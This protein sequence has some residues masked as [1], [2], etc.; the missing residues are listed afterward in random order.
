MIFDTLFSKKDTPTPEEQGVIASS[1]QKK[2]RLAPRKRLTQKSPKKKVHTA[3]CYH[4]PELQPLSQ[5]VRIFDV[6][7]RPIVTEKAAQLSE[8]GVYA[9]FV[10][11]SATKHSV[12]AA[13]EA[14]YNVSPVKVR[15]ARYPSR[16]KRVRVSGRE[17]EMGASRLRKRAYVY[18][19]EGEKIQLL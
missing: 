18:L 17:R 8:R 19:K 7:E 1:S 5:Q 12:C 16:R 3:R 4:P 13:V 10:H 6:L 9:F 11:P 2:K 14:V 15:I